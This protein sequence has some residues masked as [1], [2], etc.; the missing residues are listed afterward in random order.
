VHGRLRVR[1][2]RVQSRPELVE[3]GEIRRRGRDVRFPVHA[4]KHISQQLSTTAIREFQRCH[5]PRGCR[6]G[7]PDVHGWP[8]VDHDST[9]F[10]PERSPSQGVYQ[11]P[12]VFPAPVIKVGNT[13]L[14]ENRIVCHRRWNALQLPVSLLHSVTLKCRRRPIRSVR[15]AAGQRRAGGPRYFKSGTY[16]LIDR[17]PG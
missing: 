17:S 2:Q 13:S 4:R 1:R 8:L 14:A 6:Q 5:R 11:V 12:L 7:D 9:Q 3:A 16:E 10:W 15:G